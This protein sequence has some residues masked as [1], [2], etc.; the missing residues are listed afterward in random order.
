MNLGGFVEICWRMNVLLGQNRKGLA[1][2]AG[3]P[4]ENKTNHFNRSPFREIVRKLMWFKRFW[5]SQRWICQSLVYSAK[6]E[7]YLQ[8]LKQAAWPIFLFVGGCLG[9]LMGLVSAE[10]FLDVF[11]IYFIS[12]YWLGVLNTLKP[13]TINKDTIFLHGNGP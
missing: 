2:F 7:R 9:A 6:Q 8:A 3:L 13:Q 5:K 11:Q 10:L 12:I 4:K 1:F